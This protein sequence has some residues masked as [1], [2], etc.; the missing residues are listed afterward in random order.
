MMQSRGHVRR[1]IAILMLTSAAAAL[2]GGCT[3]FGVDGDTARARKIRSN[4]T[5]ELVT[6][7]QR[8]VDVAN[9]MALT[10][11]ENGRMARQDWG[12][13]WL[14][15]RPSRLAREPIPR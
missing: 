6:L 8:E 5:P 14:M 1:P 11:D 2:L 7:H 13:L 9:A 4:P 3:T 12:R 15:D 10:N